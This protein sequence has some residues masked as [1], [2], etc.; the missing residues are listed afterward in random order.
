[1]QTIKDLFFF[2]FVQYNYVQNKRTVRH[3]LSH[4]SDSTLCTLSVCLDGEEE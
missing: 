4:T 2:D 3:C 1:M